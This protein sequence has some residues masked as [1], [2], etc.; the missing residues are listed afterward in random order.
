MCWMKE[1]MVV[2]K[3]HDKKDISLTCHDVFFQEITPRFGPKKM[4]P[5]I[6]LDYNKTMGGV[7]RAD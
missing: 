6:V 7:D 5:T 3:W 4:K 1:D 2:V